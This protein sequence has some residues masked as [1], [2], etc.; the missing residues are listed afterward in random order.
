MLVTASV[1]ARHE[2]VFQVQGVHIKM[3][4]S[5]CLISPAMNL[6]EGVIQSSVWSTKT[7]LYDIKELRYK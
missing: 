7:F 2:E 3:S 6:L 1:L 5:F 4:R